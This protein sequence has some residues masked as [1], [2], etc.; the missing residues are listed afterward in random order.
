MKNALRVRRCALVCAFALLL[1]LCG[2]AGKDLAPSPGV[3][4][5]RASGVPQTAAPAPSP[6]ETP[7]LPSPA[8]ISG[9][10]GSPWANSLVSG[11]VPAQAPD[12]R[13]DLY[14]HF[15]YD[16]LKQTEGSYIMRMLGDEGVMA[17]SV[18]T[19]ITD[20]TRGAP[21][22]AAYSDRELEQLRIFFRQACDIESIIGR[23]I[24]ELEPYLAKVRAVKTL[25]ELNAVLTGRDFPFS[26]FLL[27]TVS[28]YDMAAGNNVFLLPDFL[29]V[30]DSTGGEHFQDSD[31]PDVVE[32]NRNELNAHAPAVLLDLLAL[33]LEEEEA[34]DTLYA[35]YDLERVYGIDTGYNDLY[36]SQSF[37]TLAAANVD[38]T[39]DELAARCPNFPMRE[40]IEKFGKDISRSF[41]V[42]GE[43]WLPSLSSVW[44]EEN[45]E[46][47]KTMTMVKVLEECRLFVD[48]SAAVGET[49][50][51]DA[52]DPLANAWSVMNR[53]DTFTQLIGKI[54]V[55]ESYSDAELERIR[56][57]AEEL[58][59]TF[60]ELIDETSWL[61]ED[62]R[63]RCK[64]KLNRMRLNILCPDGGWLDFSD[65]ELLP[66]EEGGTLLGNYLRLK[67]WRCEK[68]NALLEGDALARI[69]FDSYYLSTYG[70]CAYDLDSNSINIT[71]GLAASQG[72]SADTSPE[73]LLAIFGWVIAHEISHGFDYTGAQ[74]DAYGTPN[75]LF[76]ETELEAYLSIVKKLSARY[77]QI[78]ALPGVYVV[79]DRVKTE[80]AA[81]LIGMQLV[82]R[83]A[84]EIPDF[85][86]DAFWQAFS[87]YLF[88]VLPDVEYMSIFLADEHPLHYLRCNINVQMF[89]EFYDTYDVRED[90]GM[91]LPVPERV[92]F[93]G[94]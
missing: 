84:Q 48:M 30:D 56:S 10:Y 50:D 55:S 72:Y 54:Y 70:G 67:A 57:L 20:E 53:T 15:N 66:E 27:F 31:D 92:C 7:P 28:A 76:D 41:T 90:D 8:E 42:F 24:S 1:S 12:A 37:G 78:E 75:A 19:V 26:P 59:D 43:E 2:C 49:Q 89:Q 61:G 52:I 22:E 77:D 58:I 65:L 80:A 60:C 34:T 46:L 88:M 13:D 73:T 44:T 5:P 11:N 16:T 83:L 33:G 86:Y 32:A 94:N 87:T 45:L 23:G 47:L 21:A 91:Y 38:L 4:T 6:A 9:P 85:D 71:P 69:I 3:E 25:P 40:T 82:L 36:A 79:G 14:L 68:D 74:F 64:E 17:D 63:A 51:P 93:W 39:L 29:F 35:L 81:D 18:L 62:S